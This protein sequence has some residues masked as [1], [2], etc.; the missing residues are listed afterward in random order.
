MAKSDSTAVAQAKSVLGG[1]LLPLEELQ[2]LADQLKHEKAFGFARR[3]LHQARQDPSLAEQPGLRLR[4]AQ[5]HALCTYKDPDLQAEVKF[6]AALDI[7][8][9]GE[10]LQYTT[11][12][13]TLGISGAIH[14]YQWE[15]LGQKQDLERSLLYYRRGYQQGVRSDYGYTGINA[16][17]V[18]DLLAHLEEQTAQAVGTPSETAADRRQE[19]Q[20]VRTDIIDQ[21]PALAQQQNNQW[22]GQEWWFLVTIAE[23][24]FG[25]DRYTE[26]LEWLKTAARL[27]NIPDWEREST[28]RQLAS[29]ARLRTPDG[30]LTEAAPAWQVLADFLGQEYAAGVRTAVL[31]KIGLALSGGGFRAALFHIGVLAKLAELDVLRHVEFLSCVSGGSIIG[32]HYYLELGIRSII[33]SYC[34]FRVEHRGT[35]LIR[36]AG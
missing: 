34:E 21:L 17:Y 30:R 19:A 29:L 18:L 32:A 8:Q 20:R 12:Q 10:D 27:P 6:A 24:Y 36:V 14:K 22:L 25:L 13:E 5:Q 16:A 4:L 28:A 11:N 31:G 33:H 23:A 9:T 7:L 35:Y 1:Q 26:A 2:R 15:A 3:I